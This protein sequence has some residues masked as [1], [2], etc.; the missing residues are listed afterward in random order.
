M[1]EKID[2]DTKKKISLA[3]RLHAQFNSKT[4][5]INDLKAPDKLDN[6]VS[7]KFKRD[8]S[9]TSKIIHN[10]EEEIRINKSINIRW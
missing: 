2:I 10:L 8:V 4:N 5:K 3:G 1:E 6:H 7:E 9:D